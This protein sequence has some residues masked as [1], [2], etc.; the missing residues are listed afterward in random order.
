MDDNTKLVTEFLKQSDKK[1]KNKSERISKS[2]FNREIK[3]ENVNVNEKLLKN[4]KIKIIAVATAGTIAVSS[5]ISGIAGLF[6]KH[7]EKSENK[8]TTTTSISSEVNP[9]ESTTSSVENKI[10]P[11]SINNLGIELEFPKNN[12]PK[13]EYSNPT[14]NIDV[15]KIVEGNDGTLWVNSEAAANENKIGQEVIDDKDGQ[16]E[17]KPD[18]SVYETGVGYEIVDESG[19]V[20]EQGEGTPSISEEHLYTAPDGSIWESKEVYEAYLKALE[21]SEVVISTTSDIITKEPVTSE[22]VELPVEDGY[23]TDPE[24]GLTFESKEDYEQWLIQG[25]EGYIIVDGI[26]VPIE[27]EI[28]NT[29]SIQFI[30]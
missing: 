9:V 20:I 22:P 3:K 30:R 18:G 6:K 17:V 12:E 27:D 1:S 8:N 4:K 26:M 5:L 29:D 23:Y 11:N 10:K 25:F 19:N 15:N 24:T 13:K 2:K 28:I 7:N 14:G 21:N 16:L